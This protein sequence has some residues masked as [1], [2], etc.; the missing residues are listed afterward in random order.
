MNKIILNKNFIWNTIGSTIYA[1]TSLLFMIIVTRINGVDDAGVFTFAFTFVCMIQVVG[2]YYGRAFQVTETNKNVTDS[3][4]I[5]FRII[6]CLL[7]LCCSIGFCFIKNYSFDKSLIIF[8]LTIYKLI[9]AFSEGIYGVFQKENNLFQ[10][11]ISLFI[12]SI[13]TVG[14]FLLVDLITNN[15]LLSNIS[16]IVS[17]LIVL[18]LYDIVRLKNYKI[19][20]NTLKW[21]TIKFLFIGG[22]SVFIFTFLMQYITAAPKY[23]IDEISTN[24]N[25]AIF[26]IILMPATLMTLCAQLIIY[27]VLVKLKT[28]VE[29]KS[30]KQFNKIVLYMAIA[31]IFVGIIFIVVTYLIG[32]P[33]LN[34]IYNISLDD[35]LTPLLII[36]SGSVLYGIVLLFSN[37]LIAIRVNV[38]QVVI[39]AIGS[40]S[41]FVLSYYLVQYSEIFG[42]SLSYL[43]TI[44][45]LLILYIIVYIT[46]TRRKFCKIR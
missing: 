4:F 2:T 16:L 12:R 40:I 17:S 19:R 13:L 11:G 30:L 21:K 1:A 18:F 37:A 38:I 34:L 8:V 25:Q 23:V 29:K 22:L 15:L 36:V 44:L 27:P 46:Q 39:Y 10:V 33:I 31:I 45:I 32:I 20:F 3:D 43:I 7:M 26:G 24:D 28:S 6:T 42:A 5:K 14:I 9:D 41:A 35:Y